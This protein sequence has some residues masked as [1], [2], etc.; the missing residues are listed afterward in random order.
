MLPLQIWLSWKNT[1]LPSHEKPLDDV[2]KR[3]EPTVPRAI[4]SDSECEE[5]ASNMGML[6][7]FQDMPIGERE[8]SFH[9]W[10]FRGGGNGI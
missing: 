3:Y 1:T 9:R 10:H 2:W 6:S 5:M 7:E 4:I 8:K